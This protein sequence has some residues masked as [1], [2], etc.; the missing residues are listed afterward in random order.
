METSTYDSC[1]LISSVSKGLSYNNKGFGFSTSKG[2][3]LDGFS[4]NKGL[5]LDSSSTISSTG[6]GSGLDKAL[7]F[8]ITGF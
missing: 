1:L 4:T 6:K 5:G 2:L 8:G 3:G 7:V